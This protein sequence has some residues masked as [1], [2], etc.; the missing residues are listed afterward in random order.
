[1]RSYK[2]SIFCVLILAICNTSASVG[3]VVMVQDSSMYIDGEASFFV[4]N[5]EYF[6][7]FTEGITHIGFYM[8]PRLSMPLSDR[9]LLSVGAYYR[10]YGSDVA[11][12]R[13][14][15]SFTVTHH[16]SSR[17]QLILGNIKSAE[18]H[19]LSE[20]IYREDRRFTHKMEYGLQYIH[21]SERWTTDL[22]LDWRQ[23]IQYDDPFP[24]VFFVGNRSTFRLGTLGSTQIFLEDEF[25]ISHAG[26]QID[27]FQGQ[28][29]NTY[30]IA[31]AIKGLHTLSEHTQ[32]TVQLAWHKSSGYLLP[33]PRRSEKLQGEGVHGYASMKS[34]SWSFGVGYWKGSDYTSPIGEHLFLTNLDQQKLVYHKDR[35][36]AYVKL[37]Y[38][39]TESRRIE[40]GASAYYD[41]GLKNLD[42][43]VYLY[44]TIRPKISLNIKS[45]SWLN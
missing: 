21:N 36:L 25:L 28:D 7:D 5:N 9:L 14:L 23:F 32:V 44:Y 26:G 37:R 18:N 39:P 4:K 10:Q 16:I 15:P 34:K 22:W 43:N 45:N 2:I 24:E 41:I 20:L 17:D 8:H 42:Y 11:R 30:N 31:L 1:M 38:V 33:L 6:N 27:T 19:R 3:Q 40:C 12:A 29:R 13:L 35:E